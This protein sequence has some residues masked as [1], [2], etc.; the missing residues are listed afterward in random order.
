[1]YRP[2]EIRLRPNVPPEEADVAR[3]ELAGYYAHCTALNE[4]VGKLLQTL[5]DLE[6]E[7][8]TIFI[9]TSDHG[10]MLH[11]H[12]EIRKQRP[13]DESIRVPLLIRYPRL[14]GEGGKTLDG[15]I[16]SEDLM[17]TLLGLAGVPVPASVEGKDFS[18]YMQGG[19]DPP[20]GAALI[21]CPAPFGEW[22]R[23][24]GRP[25]VPAACE[26]AAIPTCARSTAPGCFMTTKTIPTSL[27]TSSASRSTPTLQ[28]WARRRIAS[29]ASGQRRS[30]PARRGVH[31][32]VGLP[33]Q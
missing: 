18:R 10:D 24:R 17:P 28:G 16:S 19:D 25:R 27:T 13:W 14:L 11:S 23:S 5:R 1:M 31:R 33:G 9:F 20:D 4:C 2:E 29:Q 32:E 30:V 3:R 22:P 15:L 12:G 8:D 21:T 7:R 6:I 26:P